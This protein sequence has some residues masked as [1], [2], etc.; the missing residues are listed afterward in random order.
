M[1]KTKATSTGT[2]EDITTL[3]TEFYGGIQRDD[4]SNV[5]GGASDVEELDILENANFVRPTQVLSADTLPSNTAF[6]SYCEDPLNGDGYAVGADNNGYTYAQVFQNIA[7]SSTTP[8][9][10]TSKSSSSLVANPISGSTVHYEVALGATSIIPTLAIYFITGQNVISKW[11]AAGGIATT[12]GPWTL[13]TLTTTMGHVS[14]REINGITYICAGN[15][16]STIDPGSP[17]TGANFNEAAFPLPFGYVA[18]D[19]CQAGEYFFILASSSNLLANKS[20]IFIWDGVS[21]TYTDQI[22]VP[23]GGPQ[24]LYNFKQTITICCTSNGIMQLFYLSAPTI[25]AIVHKYPNIRLQNVQPDNQTQVLGANGNHGFGWVTPVSPA[26]SVFV[27]D[28]ILYFGLWKFDKTALYALGQLDIKF[29]FALWLAKRFSTAD[30]SQM[31]PYAAYC[32]GSKI[33]A[34]F[35]TGYGTQGNNA[36]QASFCDPAIASRSSQAIFQSVWEDDDAPM[37]PKILHK[38]YATSYPMP[39]G[40]SITLSVASD[41]GKT[42]SNV[43]QNSNIVMNILNAIFAMFSSTGTTNKKLFQ[44]GASFTSR[45]T[46]ATTLSAAITTYSQVSISI[47]S[48]TGIANGDIVLV[49]QEKMTVM[50]GGGT[51]S[52]I[53]TRGTNGTIETAHTN[54]TAFYDL[55]VHPTLTAVGMRK[56]IKPLDA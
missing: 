12:V 19:I 45:A 37:N 20:V 42:F 2:G 16:V 34:S 21:G 24:W 39:A 49:D 10:W 13:S 18:V 55:S 3:Q 15:N 31:I 9:G 8:G 14:F 26:K 5:G 48:G 35:Q 29:P 11:T 6:Y 33:F 30:Y 1:A 40:C 28:D 4:L 50:S 36:T 27:K 43:Y 7:I 52:L 38:L 23:M 25:G 51:T 53:V 44:W 17:S 22:P 41:Y 56:T 32:F 46:I 54:G 47:T